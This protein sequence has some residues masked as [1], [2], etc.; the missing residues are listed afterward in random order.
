[1]RGILCIALWIKALY[2]CSPFTIFTIHVDRTVVL[3][4]TSADSKGNQKPRIK[5]RYWKLTPSPRKQL[6]TLDHSETAEKLTVQL[7]LEYISYNDHPIRM[8]MP[9]D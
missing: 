7:L 4:L 1:M 5:T 8:K 6:N 3:M 9:S 2:K